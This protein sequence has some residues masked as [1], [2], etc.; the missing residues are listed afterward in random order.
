ML[1][2]EIG[3]GVGK[4]RRALVLAGFREN[5]FF[6][7]IIRRCCPMHNEREKSQAADGL[8]TWNHAQI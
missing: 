1:K 4:L 8:E 2:M 6:L 3:I 5:A 7:C